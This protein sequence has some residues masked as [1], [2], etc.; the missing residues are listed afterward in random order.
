MIEMKFYRDDEYVYI[1][2]P[3]GT[4]RKVTIE[5][6]ES[7]ISGGGSGGESGLKVVGYAEYANQNDIQIIA[8]TKFEDIEFPVGYFFDADF[9]ELPEAPSFRIGLLTYLT[10]DLNSCTFSG[11]YAP[12][13]VGEYSATIL[14]SN[15]TENN[16]TIRAN[17][18]QATFVLLG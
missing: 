16:I 5:G 1:N 10:F 8:H 12:D 15:F 4:T 11:Y 14:V 13:P 6:F 17:C 18:I 7:A 2:N 3:D 9:N